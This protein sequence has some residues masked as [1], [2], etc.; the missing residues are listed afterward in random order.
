MK[1]YNSIAEAKGKIKNSVVTTGSFD[2]VHTGHKII[3]NKLNNI[4]EKISG[5]SV[6]ITFNPHPRKILY[7]DQ[8][9]LKLI[10]TIEEKIYLLSETGLH[11]LIIH[12]FDKKFANTSS[13]EFI[14]DYLIKML[15][16]KAIVVGQ[17]HHFGQNKS[18]DYN[19]L[20]KLSNEFDFKVEEI[21]L[22]YIENESVSSVK[23]RKALQEGNVQKANLYLNYSFR[24]SGKL[25]K[26]TS[27][28]IIASEHYNFIVGDDDKLIPSNGFYAGE[29]VSNNISHK[30]LVM[31]N[32]NLNDRS[33]I[34]IV[35]PQ[36]TV[37]YNN[38]TDIVFYKRL[39]K[40]PKVVN[41]QSIKNILSKLKNYL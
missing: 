11:N 38:K 36:V 40:F 32:N 30:V 4:A 25:E 14:S 1:V 20:H 24:I 5:E 29:I 9:S 21:P 7:P 22:K 18:G 16:M 26:E 31:V 35:S 17:N 23:I 13:Y 27:N 33:E 15:D 12:P 8:K 39:E 41:Y 6:L 19:Y 10:N 2:G 37:A 34:K 3:L 28:K